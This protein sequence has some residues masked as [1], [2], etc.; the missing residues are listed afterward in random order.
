MLMTVICG[1][2]IVVLSDTVTDH[3]TVVL[4]KRRLATD[5]A[6]T[7]VVGRV[8]IINAVHETVVPTVHLLQ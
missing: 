1:W 8:H 4:D 6:G 3:R 2:L 7:A 5:A